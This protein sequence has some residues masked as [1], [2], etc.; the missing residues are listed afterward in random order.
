[1]ELYQMKKDREALTKEVETLT[2]KSEIVETEL[3]E[4]LRNAKTKIGQLKLEFNEKI[5]Q[6]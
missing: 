2:N 5:E 6:E 1:M 4:E 3:K